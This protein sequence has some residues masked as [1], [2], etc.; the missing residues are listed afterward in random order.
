MSKRR[1]D[2]WLVGTMLALLAF[3]AHSSAQSLNDKQRR[4]R[5]IATELDVDSQE[6][7]TLEKETAHAMALNNSSFF[8]RLYSDDY[9]GVAANGEIL[10]KSAL[11][12]RIQRSTI[13]YVTFVATNI[14]VR[15]YGPSAVVT[16]TWTV[17]GQQDGRNF[18]RQYR[19][20]HV[21]INGGHDGAWKVVAGQETM[22]AG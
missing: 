3:T 22:L 18:S 17:R 21:Y 13:K 19:V 8:E 5:T 20:I 2:R 1:V 14:D 16:C 15:V 12:G 10:N 6:L 9:V 11:V 4:E 7:V